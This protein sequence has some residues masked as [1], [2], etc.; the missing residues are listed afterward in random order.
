[1][2]SLS[3]SITHGRP[4]MN[5]RFRPRM[6]RRQPRATFGC[7]ARAAR[8]GRR[9]SARVAYGDSA[10]RNL[11]RRSVAY[12]ARDAATCPIAY[13]VLPAYLSGDGHAAGGH[14]SHAT[15]HCSEPTSLDDEDDRRIYRTTTSA[16]P[17]TI[18]WRASAAASFKTCRLLPPAAPC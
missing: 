11:S 15:A 6:I 18:R 13:L 10:G 17:H 9:P 2:S 12:L 3:R 7:G 5:R 16:R 4:E 1:L 8:V 14:P